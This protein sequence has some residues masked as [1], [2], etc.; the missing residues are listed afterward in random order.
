MNKEQIW[1]IVLII[2][3]ILVIHGLTKTGSPDKKE[4][5]AGQSETTLG[6]IGT[7][8]S[9]IKKRIAPAVAAA[10][11]PA[12]WPLVLTIGG[13]VFLFPHFLTNL[14]GVFK[15]TPTIPM[16]VWAVG[17]FILFLFVM[18]RGK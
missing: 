5:Q 14:F 11:A 12:L 10:A 16:W 18:R 6:T 1:N 17:F 2:S 8:S 9:I 15:S 3:I 7:I 13:L 4:A